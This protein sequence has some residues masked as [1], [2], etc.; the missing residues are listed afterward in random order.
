M[1][2]RTIAIAAACLVAFVLLASPAAARITSV[3]LRVDG[4]SCPFCAYSLEKKIKTVAGTKAPVINVDEGLVTLTPVGDVPVDFDGLREAVKKA[5]FTPR[6]TSV[7]GVG[8]VATI[9]GHAMLVAEDGVQLFLL[10]ANDVAASLDRAPDAIVTFSGTVAPLDDGETAALRT[11]VLLSAT[12]R[13]GG[14]TD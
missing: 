1:G 7:E 6:E 3:T 11:L 14:E 5:G 2:P 8:R 12:P 10:A 9:D 13:A 4:L